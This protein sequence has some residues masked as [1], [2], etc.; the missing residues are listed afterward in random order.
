MQL[1]LLQPLPPQLLHQPLQIL[2]VKCL[3]PTHLLQQLIRI[4]PAELPQQSLYGFGRDFEMP[5]QILFR[6]LLVDLDL[7]ETFEEAFVGE[8]RVAE[9][10]ALV[11]Q[12]CGVGEVA[13]HSAYREF[14]GEVQGEAVGE[15]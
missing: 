7:V 2:S 3:P 11:A 10:Q 6:G 9:G 4:L 5:V 1:L 13:L 15:A 14:A 8:D 12:D